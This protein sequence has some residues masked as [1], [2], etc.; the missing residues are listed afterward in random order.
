M[1]AL[2]TFPLGSSGGPHGVTPQHV[3]IRD[4]LSG[5]TDASLQQAL[6]DFVNLTRAGS[7]D[8]EVNSIIFGGRLIALSEKDGGIKPITVSYIP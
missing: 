3:T 4:M 5:S 1:E 7:F 2:R 6:V 8:R